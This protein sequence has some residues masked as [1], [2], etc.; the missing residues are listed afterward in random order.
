MSQVWIEDEGV[1]EAR[2]IAWIYSGVLATTL[3][4]ST[5]LRPVQELRNSGWRVTLIAAGSSGHQRI[6]DVDV[7]CFSR[8]EIYLLRQVAFHLKVLHWLYREVK[9]INVILFHETSAPWMLL[10]RALLSFRDN[11]HPL[12]VMD[13]RSL[14]MTDPEYETWKDKVRRMAFR[15]DNRIG[16]TWGDGRLAITE[17]LAEALHIPKEKL[18]GTWPS[19]A[20]VE[21]FSS[22]R[23]GR[24]WPTLEGPVRLIYHGALHRE[25]N[26]A[27][28]CEAVMRANEGGMSFSL[29]LV[30]DGTDRSRLMRLASYSK[31]CIRF[32]PRVPYLEVPRLLT[33]AHVGV[34]PFADEEKFR[35][36]SPIKLFEYMAA[37]IPILATQIVCHTD[38]VGEGKYVFWAEEADEHGLLE[39]L[40]RVWDAR[41]A[42]PEMGI[43][44]EVASNSWT[45][46]ASAGKLADA[47]ER[48]IREARN[49]PQGRRSQ[50]IA[51]R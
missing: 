9:S 15:I 1:V 49:G 24:C 14:P 45:W 26:L 46:A 37:G 36:S 6:S 40:K 2:H 21:V 8:P 5:W 10:L 4:A 34:V 38:V 22:A 43:E 51:V 17:R 25:R 39:G 7:L 16:N 31:G 13:S 23:G 19:G 30:G 29:L 12:I 42:L 48:G 32:V 3:D 41:H 33:E 35:V 28:L 11:E 27:S 18:W 44:A 50:A 20:A 47:L